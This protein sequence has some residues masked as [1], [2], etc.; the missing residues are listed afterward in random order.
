MSCPSWKESLAGRLYGELTPDEDAS[1]SSHLEGCDAC[2]T[3]LE[4]FGRVRRMM[5]DGEPAIPRA[6]RV[7]VLREKSTFR[8]ALLA[9]SM[10]GAA[11]L[12]GTGVGLVAA[13]AR[14]TAPQSPVMTASNPA[15]SAAATEE[16]VRRE[17]DRRM[18]EWEASHPAN[19][20]AGDVA[21][22]ASSASDPLVSASSL[23]SELA[24]FERRLNGARASDLDYMLE[25]IAASEDRVGSR[26]GKTND[27][28]RTVALAN[29][30]YR[31]E[32]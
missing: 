27:A 31:N 17:V 2:R 25:Q 3:T 13:K 23:R 4:E 1:L 14:G 10:L 28:L 7:L 12:A 8:P 19:T 15:T 24:K 30:P 20:H 32:Q 22:S 6:P 11:I 9:A 18:A 21:R 16:A 26:I 29:N 5:R